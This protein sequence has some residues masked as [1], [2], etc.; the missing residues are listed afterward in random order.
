[1]AGAAILCV[2]CGASQ[3]EARPACA[4][5]G[6]RTARVCAGCGAQ[7]SLA[8]NF[9]DSCGSP[10]DQAA[11][12]PPPPPGPAGSEPPLT[13]V[14]R[15]NPGAPRP[16]QAGLGGPL[17]PA[18]PLPPAKAKA[19]EPGSA[20]LPSAGRVP[21]DP[22]AAIPGDPWAPQPIRSEPTPPP[23]PRWPELAKKALHAAAATLGVLA[24][25]LGAWQWHLNQK[26]E[27][28]VPRVAAAYLDALRDGRLE[29]AYALFSTAAQKQCSLEEFVASRSTAPWTWKDLRVEHQEPGGILLSYDLEVK[30]AP[31]RRDTV[32]FTLEEGRGWVRPY[33]WTL[34]RKVEAAFDKGDADMGLLLAHQ[35][36]T[37]DPR[38]PM[39]RGYLC[40]AAYYRKAADE[41]VRQCVSALELQR[42]YP[43]KMSLKDVYHLHAILADT[44]KNSLKAPA[45]ALDQ[46]AQMLVFPNISPADQCE[47]LLARVDAYLSLSR[48]GEA[49]ADLDRAAQLCAKPQ[50]LAYIEAARRR[51]G[52]PL[53]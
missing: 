48:P 35:A 25:G 37:I 49:L 9:C 1:M 30:G 51:L 7:N 32:L 18:S 36:A 46:F 50:D 19:A 21:N 4:K 6:G 16:G 8:K 24:A 34:M 14:R 33:N 13:A 28:V 40:E 5:C 12:A 11:G 39:A 41:T 52:A 43:S 2:K 27:I 10:L 29:A 26:P 38:D 20:P 42:V 23:K 17:P 15:L 3:S 44:Y 31:P 53:P 22:F 47:I 45:K